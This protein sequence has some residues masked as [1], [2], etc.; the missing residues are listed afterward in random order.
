[1]SHVDPNG[2][3]PLSSGRP[4]TNMAVYLLDS[5][6]QEVPAGQVGEMYV[7]GVG[8]ARGY[9]NQ[10][11][12]TAER[13][14]E[15]AY[16]RAYRSY[17]LG[18][19]NKD[20]D[21]EPLGRVDD[22]VK[23]SGQSVSLGEIEQTLMRH[24]TVKVA[25]AMQHQ[26]R[27]IAFVESGEPNHVSLEDWHRFLAKTLPT[28]MLPA[29]VTTVSKIPV[30]SYGKADRQALLALAEEASQSRNGAER[31]APPQG[32][33]E[34]HIAEI[35]EEVLG[36]RPIMREDNFYALGGTSLLSIAISQR[37]HALGYAVSAQTI[38]VAATVA[39]LAGKI[40]EASAQ[41]PVAQHPDRS[42]DAATA[43]QEDFWIA[44]KLGLATAGSEIIRVLAV[45]GTVPEPARWQAA[46][47]RLVARH[48]ALRTAFFAGADDKVLWHTVEAEELAPAVRFSLDYC[49]SPNDARER[50]AAHSHA[51]RCS[52]LP[53]TMQWPTA[54]PPASSRKRC[55]LCCWIARCHR[56]STA[57][58]RPVTPNSTTWRPILPSATA[59]GGA[60]SWIP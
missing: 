18:R 14:V 23:V 41:K 13:F 3:G 47:T 38:L 17:D 59:P 48:A 43:G 19:W 55:T 22:L 32:E 46:W 40:A 37:L 8:V 36:F 29:Q 24:A 6:G 31:G 60:T 21:L 10:P 51:K 2:N 5:D 16:G 42:Q 1:M 56:P 50:I 15:T 53:C 52:G 28:Y 34:V 27:L 12:L 33:V 25:A 9:L 44:W 30:N 54:F 4:F 57:W 20:G 58:R 45:R 26:G 49:D 7:V 35:W 11:D 39:A